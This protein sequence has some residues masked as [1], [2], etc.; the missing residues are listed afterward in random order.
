MKGR[1]PPNWTSEGTGSRTIGQRWNW[2]S[3]NQ[4][5]FFY[6]SQ[7]TSYAVLGWAQAVSGLVRELGV[8]VSAATTC[9]LPG[10]L[11]T[12]HAESS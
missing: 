6:L 12:I 10:L 9:G 2:L 4:Q 5:Q 3:S 8:V 1:L 11:E 7:C